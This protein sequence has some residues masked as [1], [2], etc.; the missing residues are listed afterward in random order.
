MFSNLQLLSPLLLYG[1]SK[2]DQMLNCVGEFSSV[3]LAIT[4]SDGHSVRVCTYLQDCGR[5]NLRSERPELESC[6][7]EVRD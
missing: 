7:D 3:D 4:R 2:P 5:T 6:A 1:E